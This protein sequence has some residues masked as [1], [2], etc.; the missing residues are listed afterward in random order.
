MSNEVD[1][2][3]MKVIFSTKADVRKAVLITFIAFLFCGFQAAIYGMTTV[4]VSEFFGKTPERIVF[5]DSFG[6]WG[7]I[8][9]MATGG[10]V[11]SKIKGKNTLLLAGFMML[12]ASS[13]IALFP[14]I[15]IYMSMSFICNM[16]VGFVLVACYYMTMGTVRRKGESEGKLAILNVFFSAGFMISPIVN[17]FVI[18]A[19]S[20]RTVFG[21]IAA[22]FIIFVAILLFMNISELADKEI[23][24]RKTEKEAAKEKESFMSLPLILTAIAFFLF[25]YVEQIMNNLNQPRMQ[26]D[27]GFSI[28]L[29]GAMVTTYA[30]SQMFGRLVFGKF[31]LPR[32]KAYKYIIIS[33]L[34][35]GAFILVFVN[36]RSLYAVIPFMVLLGLANSCIYPSIVGYGLDQIGH[37]SPK[38]TSFIITCGSIGIPIGTGMSGLIGEHFGRANAMMVGPVLLVVVVLLIATVRRMAVKKQAG[39]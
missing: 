16:A 5:F 13:L 24:D 7:Q 37:A 12:I 9:A 32:V 33:S 39:Q 28:K 1:S 25:V 19:T 29:V 8:L 18:A 26:V 22:M 4:P 21:M 30:L 10:F 31:L 20:W 23:R 11:I 14:V 15:P 35:F 2:A 27:L 6:M 17:G 36:L 3:E 34:L 38:A